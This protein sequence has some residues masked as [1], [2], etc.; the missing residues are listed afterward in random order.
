M[1]THISYSTH[2]SSLICSSWLKKKTILFAALSPSSYSYALFF[3]FCFS[4]CFNKW[5]AASFLLFISFAW[6]MYTYNG[7]PCCYLSFRVFH[8]RFFFLYNF[9]PLLL[10]LFL[11]LLIFTNKASYTL[12]CTHIQRQPNKYNK[13]K[14]SFIMVLLKRENRLEIYT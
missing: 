3:I 5:R 6:T 12:I 1:C 9:F 10:L 8:F 2:G 13:T 4:F 11:F 14:H 7:K